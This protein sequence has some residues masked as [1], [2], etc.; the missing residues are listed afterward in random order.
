MGFGSTV[1]PYNE[2]GY[3]G[4][5]LDLLITN[6]AQYESESQLTKDWLLAGGTG[7]HFVCSNGWGTHGTIFPCSS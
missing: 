5:S 2:P 6:I 1:V 4:L 3:I 7:E